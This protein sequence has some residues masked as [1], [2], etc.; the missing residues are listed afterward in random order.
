[1]KHVYRHF[2]IVAMPEGGTLKFRG[3]SVFGWFYVGLWWRSMA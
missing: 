1:M 2:D 3:I